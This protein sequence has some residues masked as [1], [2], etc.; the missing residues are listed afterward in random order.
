MSA[1]KLVEFDDGLKVFAS[2]SMEARFIYDEIF[3]LG[4]YDGIRLPPQPLVIDVG[5]NIGMFAL[6]V[7]LRYP[8]AEILAFE[9]APESANIFRQNMGLHG[10]DGVQVAEIA[11]GSSQ[12]RA[13]PFTYY[14]AIPGNSTR[15]PG[16]KGPAKA[17]LSKIYSARVAER[18]YKGSDITVPVE[19]LSAFL[20]AGRPVDL[21][22]IDVEGSEVDVLRGIDPE[23]WPLIRQAVIEVEVELEEDGR[24]LDSVCDLLR[25][26]GLDPSVGPEPEEGAAPTRIVHATRPGPDRP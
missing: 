26:H 2:S 20:S 1:S 10:L 15:Y 18:L 17:A 11:L 19:R 4:C 3:R 24:R 21:L 9:P 22:K 23:H 7:K 5:A 14:P 6:F 25:A 13:A 12:E 8:D 16:Q